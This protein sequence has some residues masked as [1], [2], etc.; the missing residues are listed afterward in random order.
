M[1]NAPRQFSPRGFKPAT[2]RKA[3]EKT[4]GKKRTLTGRKLQETKKAILERDN[5]TCQQCGRLVEYKESIL[6]HIIPIARG[7]TDE[8]S[9]LEILC[10]PCSDKKTQRESNGVKSYW[11]PP[12]TQAR[13]E[14][15]P[16][17]PR[18]NS[19]Q[20][21]RILKIVCGPPGSG[22]TTYVNQHKQPGEIVFDYD[23]IAEA[24]GAKPYECP[25]HMVETIEAIRETILRTTTT[26]TWII[27]TD[28]ARAKEAATRFNGQ[29][30][31]MDTPR[32]VCTDRLRKENRPRLEQRINRVYEWFEEQAG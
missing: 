18:A 15:P 27:Y 32:D 25:S 14:P 21:H 13:P 24:L 2:P 29:L 4:H 28:L 11:N 23:Y 20:S 22:K 10:K 6:D 9:N 3:W 7:G 19:M 16:A 30:K 26:T 31:V 12:S 17:P 1:P 8:W 5:Y